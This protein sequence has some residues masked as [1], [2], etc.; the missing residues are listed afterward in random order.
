MNESTVFVFE[1]GRETERELDRDRKR[2]REMGT[3]VEGG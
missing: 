2:E 3:E 1:Q